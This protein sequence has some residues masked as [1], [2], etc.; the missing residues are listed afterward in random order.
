MPKTMAMCLRATGLV[1]LAI[2][3]FC[4][5]N[6]AVKGHIAPST[7]HGMETARYLLGA[8]EGETPRPIAEQELVL[9]KRRSQ[10]LGVDQTP[11]SDST[12]VIG[13]IFP[14]H[15]SEHEQLENIARRGHPRHEL[16]CQLR[17][18]DPTMHLHPGNAPPQC[19]PGSAG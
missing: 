6:H 19:Q 2:V 14:K 17:F 1:L 18:S 10:T 16:A 3:L 12:R 13:E 9:K 11:A 8:D 4:A 7:A 5:W 15:E